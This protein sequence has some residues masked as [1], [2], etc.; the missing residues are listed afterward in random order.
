[1][2]EVIEKSWGYVVRSAGFHD[3]F[4]CR[5]NA[6]LAARILATAE[7]VLEDH[8]V[9]VWVPMGEGETVRLDI[10]ARP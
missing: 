1:M 3:T 7:A 5:A 2:V 8:D 9:D 6:I 10:L 4:Q